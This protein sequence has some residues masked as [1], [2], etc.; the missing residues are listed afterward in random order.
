MCW[1]LCLNIPPL[2]CICLLY[3]YSS[4]RSQLSHH[5]QKKAFLDTQA[6]LSRHHLYSPLGLCL[7]YPVAT[8][9]WMPLG[10]V[11]MGRGRVTPASL[12]HSPGAEDTCLLVHSFFNSLITSWSPLHFLVFN[13]S[14]GPLVLPEALSVPIRVPGLGTQSQTPGAL[15]V[16]CRHLARPLPVMRLVLSQCWEGTTR[17]DLWKRFLGNVH[18]LWDEFWKI[19]GVGVDG[20]WR[21]GHR[22]PGGWH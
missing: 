11:G 15:S 4:S 16:N 14:F 2:P 17:L 20:E 19:R 7:H 8:H 22:W 10:V 18:E 12:C 9:Y 21:E 1:F 3:Y 13:F 6:R 5:F